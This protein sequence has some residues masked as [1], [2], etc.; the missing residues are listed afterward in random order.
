MEIGSNTLGVVVF[1]DINVNGHY[2]TDTTSLRWVHRPT[3]WSLVS[4][5]HPSY[6]FEIPLS[7]SLVENLKFR[8]ILTRLWTGR[9]W[10]LE[11]WK[12]CAFVLVKSRP[13]IRSTLTNQASPRSP[14]SGIKWN[15]FWIP[16]CNNSIYLKTWT[17]PWPILDHLKDP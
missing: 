13:A 1:H 10:S 11:Y 12:I 14:T 6:F 4:N 16:R 9:H 17:P 8:L 3:E 2:L 15:D 7:L 5:C